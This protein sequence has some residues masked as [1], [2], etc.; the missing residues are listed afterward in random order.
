MRKP[1]ISEHAVF[2]YLERTGRIDREAVEREIMMPGLIAASNAGAVAY[3]ANGVTFLL[4]NNT[5]VTV[6]DN[7]RPA[8]VAH[9]ND[10]R[11][12]LGVA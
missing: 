7:A 3:K 6:I 10:L 8:N 5:V 1:K 4:K 9:D 2:R 11:K 12:R